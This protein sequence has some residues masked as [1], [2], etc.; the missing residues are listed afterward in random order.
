MK[1]LIRILKYIIE[2]YTGDQILIYQMGKVGSSTLEKSISKLG[3]NVRHIHSFGNTSNYNFN[4][5]SKLK[6]IKKIIMKNIYKLTFRMRRKNIRIITLMR[7]PVSRNISTLFQELPAMLYKHEKNNNR[8][9]QKLDIMLDEFLEEY[10]DGN[11][12]LKWFDEEL[13]YFMGIDLFNYPFDKERGSLYIKEGKIELLVLTAEKL[14][15]NK[16]IIVE[17]INNE[18]FEFINTNISSEKWYSEINKNFKDNHKINFRKYEHFYNSKT[19]NYFYSKE[20]ILNFKNK[21]L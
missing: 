18:S 6:G 9:E 5:E 17:F 12:P 13:K 11:I 15:Y 19:V 7:D 20:D 4:K 16:D 10:V 21:W 1:K 8:R 14:N 2:L 3:I